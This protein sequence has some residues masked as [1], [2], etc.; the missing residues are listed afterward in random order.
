MD[1]YDPAR[2]DGQG[3]LGAFDPSRSQSLQGRALFAAFHQTAT[4]FLAYVPE[5]GAGDR[6]RIYDAT[7]ASVAAHT[8]PSIDFNRATCLNAHIML[9]SADGKTANLVC[10]GDHAGPGSFVFLDLQANSVISSVPLGI[11]PD[12]MAFVPPSSP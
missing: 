7:A 12:G 9:L 8:P 1:V 2:P 6:I 5:Q 3:G 11:F 10:E 4:G